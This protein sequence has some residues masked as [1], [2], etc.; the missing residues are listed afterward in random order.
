MI[1]LSDPMYQGG[2]FG[3]KQYKLTLA[4]LKENIKLLNEIKETLSAEGR[5]QSH[6]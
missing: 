3:Y 1:L 5:A 6:T 4:D 2:F